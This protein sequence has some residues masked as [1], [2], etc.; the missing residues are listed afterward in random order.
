VLISVP[1]N[2]KIHT[3][4][5]LRFKNNASWHLE[6]SGVTQ[7]KGL[8]C[9]HVVAIAK[10]TK[11]EELNL[12]SL[13]PFWWTTAAW[14]QQFPKNTSIGTSIDIEYLKEK[15]EVDNSIHYCPNFAAVRKKGQPKKEL[16][17]E[18]SKGVQKKRKQVATE[19]DLIGKSKDGAEGC[20]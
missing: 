15:Y 1:T 11:V 14:K 17:L 9:C 7:V 10:S 19:V 6:K 2:P 12:V 13:M 16:A 5:H 18:K 20:V 3:A 8:P 4:H